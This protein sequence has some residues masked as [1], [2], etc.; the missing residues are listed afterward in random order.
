MTKPVPHPWSLN[1]QATSASLQTL[2]DAIEYQQFPP[3]CKAKRA[4]VQSLTNNTFEPIAW[5]AADA[6]DPYGMHS[7]SVNNS[8]ITPAEDGLYW[9]HGHGAWANNSAGV[10][11]LM[12]RKNAAGNPVGGTEIAVFTYVNVSGFLAQGAFVYPELLLTTDY[13]ELF[14]FQNSGGA[15]DF[16]ATSA[17][18]H[19]GIALAAY[20]A[21]SLSP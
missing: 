1:E 9:I 21:T 2:T 19:F 5:S 20:D 12:V 6:Y 4:A 17:G 8:R 11:R 10:R 15:L 18:V 16:D 13:V 14:A 7:P 3:R